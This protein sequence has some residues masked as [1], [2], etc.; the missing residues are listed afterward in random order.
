M[1]HCG[2]L[3]VPQSRTFLGNGGF[4]MGKSDHSSLLHIVRACIN[5]V[6]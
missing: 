6:P 2:L 1:G 3:T 5:V 4:V